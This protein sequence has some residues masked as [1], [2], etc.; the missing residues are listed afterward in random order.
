M[1]SETLQSNY[2]TVA[3]QDWVNKVTTEIKGKNPD[4]LH[5]RLLDGRIQKILYT[6]EDCK[7]MTFPQLRNG[8]TW[9]RLITY[10][11]SESK[12]LNKQILQDVQGRYI[13]P[14]CFNRQFLEYFGNR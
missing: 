2:S 8:G 9:K 4:S 14:F 10:V 3:L 7:G 12:Q 1:P 5:R 11:P 13:I 6:S